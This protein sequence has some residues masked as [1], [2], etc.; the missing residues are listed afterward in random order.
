[1]SRRDQGREKEHWGSSVGVVL[2][3]AGGAIGLGNFL[4]FPG[5]VA[6]YGGGA[7]MI[8]YFISMLIV[9]IP[10]AWSEWALGRAG[11]RRGYHSQPAIYRAAGNDKTIWGVCGGICSLAPLVICMY[12]VF[13]ESWCLLYA[14]QYLGGLLRPLGLG[15]SL[16]PTLDAGL[17]LSDSAGYEAFF[18]QF[19]GMSGGDGSLFRDIFSSPLLLATAACALTNFTLIYF[20]IAKGIERF[21]KIATPLLLLCS[22]LVILRVATLGNPTGVEGQG[23][24]DGLGFMWNPSRPI[25]DASGAVVGR[26]SVWTALANPEVWLAATA[27]IFFSV[28]ICLC[29][30]TSYASYVKPND[31]I[32]LSGLT[33]VA[34]NGFCEVAFGGLMTI[35]AAIMF[36]GVAAAGNFESTFAMGFVVL[37]NVF[38][39]M[40]GGDFFGFLFFSLLFLA[41]LTSSISLVQPTVALTQEAFRWSR[42]VSVAATLATNL[43]GIGVV[44]WFTKNLAALDSFDF[45]LAN[46][47]PFVFA[48]LQTG[49]VAWVWGTDKMTAELERGAKIRIPRLLGFVVKFVSTP[50]LAIIFAFWLWNNLGARL[51]GVA[52]DRAAQVTL[53]FIGV[54]TATLI[55]VSLKASR[56][57]RREEESAEQAEQAQHISAI[58]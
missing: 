14:L 41:G 13:I 29:A 39:L 12:Y 32:A 46:F 2:A 45:W 42:G 47:T 10:L 7:F 4:R 23:F 22:V 38:G 27:Q 56:R 11:G 51:A 53:A 43:V 34:A 44:C 48:L 5:Q 28:S 50:Y 30:I 16:F 19:V 18:A 15:F 3:V 36:L 52:H 58:K 55:V 25:L 20:G 17:K 37:P 40:A 57:W 54:L 33:A 35:P 8:P 1:M 31:D 21:C 24:I 6:T 9:A 26:T 49:L